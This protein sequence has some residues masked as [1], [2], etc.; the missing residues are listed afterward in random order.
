MPRGV[1]AAGGVGNDAKGQR[2]P[3]WGRSAMEG[4]H[5]RQSLG[6]PPWW[7]AHPVCLAHREGRWGL[8]TQTGV[9]SP[10]VLLSHL[11]SSHYEG[12]PPA[13]PTLDLGCRGNAWA[14]ALRILST[15]RD[16]RESETTSTLPVW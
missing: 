6:E 16:T 8:L 1:T 5:A 14:P 2:R 9:G 13:S 4:A 15:R 3:P 10:S 12:M 11:P 7:E